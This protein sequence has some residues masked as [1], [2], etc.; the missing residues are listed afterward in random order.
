MTQS[1]EQ[2]RA[3]TAHAQVS[4]VPD[5]DWDKYRTATLKAQA[6]I[7][8]GGLCQAVHFLQNKDKE[9]GARIL[10]AHLQQHLREGNAISDGDFLERVRRAELPEY[11]TATREALQCLVW[12]CRMVESPK[13]EKETDLKKSGGR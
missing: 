1:R 2:E 8:N 4:K 10:V 3:I 6:L 13:A 9:G 5:R 11:L 12:Q 7:R